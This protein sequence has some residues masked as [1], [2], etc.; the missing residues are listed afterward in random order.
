MITERKK[1]LPTK[2]RKP[3]FPVSALCMQSQ[4]VLRNIKE[5]NPL[6]IFPETTKAP[7]ECIPEE[8]SS[9]SVFNCHF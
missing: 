6:K 7:Q 2:I 3:K 4:C 1:T 8:E 5:M 9:S